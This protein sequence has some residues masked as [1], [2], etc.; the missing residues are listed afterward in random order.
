V[1]IPRRKLVLSSLVALLAT[2]ALAYRLC[3]HETPPLQQDL[4]E[5]YQRIGNGMSE[6][7]VDALLGEPESCMTVGYFGC[8]GIEPLS[9]FGAVRQKTWVYDPDGAMWIIMVGFDDPGHVKCK[10]S[11]RE[12]W[13][14]PPN[15]ADEVKA[16]LEGMFSKARRLFG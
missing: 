13:Y 16:F 5:A 10:S 9:N 14:D 2:C 3:R 7:E 11:S 6:T 1:R 15:V 8:C 4:R 12:L